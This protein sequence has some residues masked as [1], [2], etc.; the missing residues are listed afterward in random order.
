[1]GLSYNDSVVL[2]IIFNGSGVPAR[3]AAGY[4]ADRYFGALNTFVPL[5]I[6]N[7]ILAFSWLGVSGGASLYAYV[8][9]YGLTQS[10]LQALLPTCI[11]SLTPDV[12]K[13]G[14]RFGMAWSVMSFAGLTGPPIG[15]ALLRTD[16]GSWMPAQVWAGVSMLL[17]AALVTAARMSRFGLQKV[18]C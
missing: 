6:L 4:L 8:A 17:G 14:V 10:A 15:G 11:S 5:F 16:H 3:I 13:T 2:L 9:I 12:R 18:K 1:M 7:A